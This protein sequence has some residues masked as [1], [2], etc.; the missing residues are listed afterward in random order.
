V[1]PSLAESEQV[2]DFLLNGM[3]R[4]VRSDLWSGPVLPALVDPAGD[5]IA[6][7]RGQPATVADCVENALERASGPAGRTDRLAERVR[8]VL[9]DL[10]YLVFV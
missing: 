4:R 7:R 1:F 6:R 3:I 10:L 8:E 2:S 9:N 5:D